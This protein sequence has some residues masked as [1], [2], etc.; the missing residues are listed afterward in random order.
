MKKNYSH[1]SSS[2]SFSTSFSFA[3]AAAA[4]SSS[5]FSSAA[6]Q[7]SK[8]WRFSSNHRFL[9]TLFFIFRASCWH[10][11]YNLIC[12]SLSDIPWYLSTDTWTKLASIS[13]TSSSPSVKGSSDQDSQVEQ[14]VGCMKSSPSLFGMNLGICGRKEKW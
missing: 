5:F 3:A 6:I 13:S 1:F 12:I 2:T 10:R 4:S 9:S 8:D 11:E 14:S 7:A